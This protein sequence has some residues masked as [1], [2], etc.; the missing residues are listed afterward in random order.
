MTGAGRAPRPRRSRAISDL[1]DAGTT[2]PPDWAQLS[3]GRLRPIATPGGG[4]GVQYGLD[5]ARLP[6]WFATACGPSARALAASWW[7]NVLSTRRPLGPRKRSRS[8]G[9]TIDPNKSAL[10]LLAGAAAA[11]AAGETSAAASLSRRAAALA[12]DSPDLLR[13]RLGRA[14]P[15]SARALD[16]SLRL[17]RRLD[18]PRRRD[19][20][21]AVRA[22]GRPARAAGSCPMATSGSH[23]RSRPRAPSCRGR[24][25]RRRTR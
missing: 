20:R 1:T 25:A 13:E 8:S 23:R 14:R 18:R 6:V 11:T 3:G 9:A 16:R 15:G 17:R 4:A 24:R 22:R 2:L 19:R 10:T 12:R 5:A 21:G 7:R